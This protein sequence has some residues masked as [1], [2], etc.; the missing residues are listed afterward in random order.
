VAVEV[1]VRVLLPRLLTDFCTEALA[2]VPAAIRMITAATPM[3]IPDIV[4][5]D[6]SLFASTPRTANRA[7]S[8]TFTT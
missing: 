3:K 4:S 2:P 7:L 5:S 1:I 6:R 8:R